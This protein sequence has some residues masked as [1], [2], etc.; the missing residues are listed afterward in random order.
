MNNHHFYETNLKEDDEMD[1]DDDEDEAS[2]IFYNDLYKLDLTSFK[3]T[4]LQLRFIL[5]NNKLIII[6][7]F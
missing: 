2:S 7:Y 5:E 3:W 1:D 4:Q 6:K